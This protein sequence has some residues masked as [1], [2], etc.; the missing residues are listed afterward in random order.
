MR[1]DKKNR[2]VVVADDFS[3]SDEIGGLL[4]LSG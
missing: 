1:K 2:M 4:Q 3:D